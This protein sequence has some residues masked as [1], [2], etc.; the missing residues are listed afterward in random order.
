MSL[1]GRWIVLVCVLCSIPVQAATVFSEDF[2]DGNFNGWSIGGTGAGAIANLYGSNYSLRLRYART[3]TRTVSTSGYSAVSISTSIAASQLEGSDQCTAEV[4]S[5]AGSSWTAVNSVAN[6]QDDGVTLYTTQASPAGADNNGA[7]QIRLRS[8]GNSNSDYCYFDNIVVTGTETTPPASCDYDCLPGNGNV[9]RSALTYS[10]LQTPGTGSLVDLSAFAVPANAANPANMFQGTLAFSAVQRGWTSVRD[11]HGYAAISGIK[12]L[13]NFNYQFVQHGTHLIP[14]SRGLVITSHPVWELILEPGRVWDESSDNGYSRA[15]IPFALQEYG[16]NCTHNGVLSF[17][18]KND[19]SMSSLAY[20]IASETCNYYQFNLYGQLAASYAPGTV[21]NAAAIKSA[22]ETEIANR[23][24]VKAIGAL[25]TDYP[26]SGINIATL[27]SEQGASARSAFGVAYNGVHYT[28]ACTTRYGDYPYCDVLDLPSYSVAKSV[29]GAYGLMALEH[30]Y[31]G[32]RNTSISSQVSACPASRW[33]DVSLEEA[34]D[35]ATGN[36]TSSGFEVDEGSSAMVNDFF[37]D[38][39]DSGMTTFA[40]GYPR[41]STPGSLW[42][43]HTSDTYLLGR[44][45][46]GY[47]AADSFNWMVE[48]IYTPL[49]LSPTAKAMIRTFDTANQQVSGYGLTFHRDD[50]VKLAEFLNTAGGAIAGVQKL[51]PAMVNETLQ[52]TAYHGLTAGSAYDF[53]DNG[54][55][56]WKADAALGCGSARY[57]PYMSGFGGISVVLLPNNMVYYFFSDNAEY[58]FNNSVGELDKIGDFCN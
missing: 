24:P 11:T 32:L 20:E 2:Q 19:G 44:A 39:T 58:T 26:G 15:A 49:K 52:N 22:Y 3:A 50:V 54:F 33:S 28:G 53:Y 30:A 1:P 23:M 40:C 46:D 43:Y 4:S 29:Y 14:V 13:P 25:A 56:I 27:G 34:L 12:T 8:A 7:F 41:K 55:W 51:D 17:L 16:A 31:P 42:V 18:F 45:L 6:G 35:M 47:L 38:Y 57:I 48:N 36:Y 37:L 21:A 10:T 5:N 9:S